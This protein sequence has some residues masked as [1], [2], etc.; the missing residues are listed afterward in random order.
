M[1]PADPKGLPGPHGFIKFG[2]VLDRRCCKNQG[3]YI[4]PGKNGAEEFTRGM[5]PLRNWVQIFGLI[6]SSRPNGTLNETDLCQFSKIY[7]QRKHYSVNTY[8]PRSLDPF[9]IVSYYVKTSWTY[10]SCA[11]TRIVSWQSGLEL[12]LIPALGIDDKLCLSH[13]SSI[14]ILIKAAAVESINRH[15]FNIMGAIEI[16]ANLYCNCLFLYWEGCVIC[17]IYLR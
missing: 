10:C 16:T 5:R 2:L 7:I 17:S 11:S 15:L 8:C 3:L 13:D 4:N 1:G 9:Y 14:S 12:V 6:G